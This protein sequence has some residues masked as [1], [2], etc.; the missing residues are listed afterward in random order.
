MA[1]R[2]RFWRNLFKTSVKIVILLFLLGGVVYGGLRLW[3]YFFDANQSFHL[4]TME[5]ETNGLLTSKDIQQILELNDESNVLFLDIS[6]L[7]KKL[8]ERSDIESAVIRRE[9]PSTL[10]VELEERVPVAWVE[11]P[12]NRI[13]AR[14]ESGSLLIDG[15]GNLFEYDVLRHMRYVNEPVLSL[16]SPTNLE[17]KSGARVVDES[18]K[19]AL[20]FIRVSKQ[21]VSEGLPLVTAV[22]FVNDWSLLVRF[23][24]GMEIT[25][26]LYDHERQL[27][28]LAIIVAHAA[29]TKRRVISGNLVPERNIPIVFDNELTPTI[30]AAEIVDEEVNVE[31]VREEAKTKVKKSVKKADWSKG[32]SRLEEGNKAKKVTEKEDSS[33][34]KLTLK[35]KGKVQQSDNDSTKSKPKSSSRKRVK[36]PVQS[37][38]KTKKDSHKK[39]ADSAKQSS[40][41]PVNKPA[42]QRSSGS[43]PASKPAAP[44]IPDFNW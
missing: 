13:Y 34:L 15:S 24:D 35:R 16:P 28:D 6:Q 18:V 2:R 9:L 7:E 14:R 29:K 3:Q 38:S 37:A 20:S 30:V 25:F 5:Y 22:K 17:Y 8:L 4:K 26:G 23:T 36:E 21:F 11:Y 31:P 42:T 27:N 40:S 10:V 1:L 33:S 44:S 32:K 19:R 41:K 12:Q 43:S 39:S